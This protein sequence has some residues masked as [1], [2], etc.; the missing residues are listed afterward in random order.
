MQSAGTIGA[1][2]LGDAQSA[3]SPLPFVLLLPV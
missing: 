3:V 2:L 1:E